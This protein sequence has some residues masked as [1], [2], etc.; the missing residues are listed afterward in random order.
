VTREEVRNALHI[1][2]T[3][4]KLRGI[5]ARRAAKAVGTPAHEDVKYRLVGEAFKR[6]AARA[7][8]RPVA[9]DLFDVLYQ[10]AAAGYDDARLDAML[11]AAH[12]TAMTTLDLVQKG[13]LR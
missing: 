2:E 11:A 7:L 12:D 8:G 3:S 9:G 1:A 5:A 10:M 6:A 13:R 4:R